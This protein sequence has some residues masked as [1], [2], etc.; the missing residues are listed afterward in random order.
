MA[1]L[2]AQ[3]AV[4]T[5]LDVAFTAAAAVGDTFQANDHG[6]LRVNNAS[7]AAVTVTVAVPGQTKYGQPLPDIDV[8]VPAGAQR[9]LGPFQG[10]L[11]DPADKL[12]HV[13]YSA[14]AS[15]TV[16]YVTV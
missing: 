12:V 11:V 6:E 10:D 7:A 1:L 9:T 14:V 4:I 5:G 15:V 16:A 2:T 8:N 3:K 13:T